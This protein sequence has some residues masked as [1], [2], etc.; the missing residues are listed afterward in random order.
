MIVP[1]Q[2]KVN[3]TAREPLSVLLDSGNTASH[4]DKPF[5]RGLPYG[6]HLNPVLP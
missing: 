3:K 4:L 2:P 6:G 1:V 5:C